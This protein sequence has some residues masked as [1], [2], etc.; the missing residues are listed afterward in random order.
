MTY[1]HIWGGLAEGVCIKTKA[2]EKVSHGK[3][4]L[5]LHSY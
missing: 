1:V 4:S 2:R 5:T 3:E